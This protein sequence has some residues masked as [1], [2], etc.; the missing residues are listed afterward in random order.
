MTREVEVILKLD[1]LR[2]SFQLVPLHWSFQPASN[3]AFV[4]PNLTVTSQHLYKSMR[5]IIHS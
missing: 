4:N 2:Q 3:R 1:P 5:N